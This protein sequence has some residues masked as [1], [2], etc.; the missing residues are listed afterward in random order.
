MHLGKPGNDRVARRYMGAPLFRAQCPAQIPARTAQRGARLC[1]EVA[2]VENHSLDDCT[3][4]FGDH[5]WT[6]VDWK[7]KTDLG[8]DE[9]KPV[10]LRFKLDQAEIYGLEF[11]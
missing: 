10:T 7:G 2:G 9:G 6:T 11:E 3:R 5:Y 8:F 4:I 1:D